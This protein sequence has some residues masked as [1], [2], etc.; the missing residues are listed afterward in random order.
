M[1]RL[2]ARAAAL[3]YVIWGLLHINAAYG[4]LRLGQSQD[5]G[6]VQG[7]VFQD[8]WNIMAGAV[9]AIVVGLTMNWRNSRVGF[10]LNFTM[11]AL[12]DIPFV[13]FVLVPGY[14]PWWPGLAGPVAWVVAAT[15]SAVALVGRHRTAGRLSSVTPRDAVAGSRP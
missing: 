6:M 12:L 1:H 11:V 2:V 10:W 8:A 13:L 15:L 5:P 9:V 14:A 3:C 7:R 4:L